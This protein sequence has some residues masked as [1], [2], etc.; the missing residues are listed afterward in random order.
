[1]NVPS[2]RLFIGSLIAL[3]FIGCGGSGEYRKTGGKYASRGPS[4]D[5][6]V[7]RNRIVEPYE[8]VGVIDIDAFS[9][10]QLPSNEDEFRKVVGKYV[11]MSGGHAVIPSLNM[12]GRWVQGTVI[13]FRPSECD[14]CRTGSIM[15]EPPNE[16][17]TS[18]DEG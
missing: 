16:D 12:H 14:R 4:C 11:C 10:P 2:T 8:E 18:K 3:V 17:P 6:R 13:R 15:R 9:V 1:M 5:Y 7:I